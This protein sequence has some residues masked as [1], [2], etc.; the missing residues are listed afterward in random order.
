MAHRAVEHVQRPGQREPQLDEPGEPARAGHRA[1]RGRPRRGEAERRGRVDGV[2]DV[3][4]VREGLGPVLGGMHRRVGRDEVGLPPGRSALRVV[5]VQGRLVVGVGVAEQRLE[6]GAVGPRPREHAEVVVPD[7]VA[8]VPEQGAVGLVHGDAQ[9]LAVHVVALG[10][11]EGDDAVGVAGRHRVLVA[12]EQ[13]EGQPTLGVGAPVGDRQPE[14]QQLDDEPALGPLGGLEPGHLRGPRRRVGS[15]SA[16]TT[17]TAVDHRPTAGVTTQLQP[18]VSRFAHIR[19]SGSSTVRPS[20][21]TSANSRRST[22]N[23]IPL[24]HDR[25]TE[26]SNASRWPQWGQAKSRTTHQPT[27]AAAARSPAVRRPRGGSAALSPGRPVRRPH[28]RRAARPRRW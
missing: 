28:D 14:L 1:R 15:G 25:Q 18:A 17:G 8:E 24:E 3:Q 13:V 20:R 10:E 4:V 2:A 27:E 16:R 11:V 5:P 12:R 22:S 9:L 7:L 23:P 26:F 19:R 21:P 6:L